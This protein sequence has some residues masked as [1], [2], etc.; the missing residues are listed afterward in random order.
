V[1]LCLFG[2]FSGLQGQTLSFADRYGT[3]YDYAELQFTEN[4]NPACDC[5]EFSDLSTGV[6]RLY[7]SEVTENTGTGFASVSQGAALRRSVCAAYAALN[8]LLQPAAPLCAAESPPRINVRV[9][10]LP[11]TQGEARSSA[12]YSLAQGY[13]GRLFGAPWWVFHTGSAPRG[14]A[15]DVFHAYLE[16]NTG[17]TLSAG[18]FPVESSSS[19]SQEALGGWLLHQALAG[20]GIASGFLN[21]QPLLH[22]HTS[23]PLFLELDPLLVSTEGTSPKPL[24]LPPLTED[25]DRQ[26]WTLND[27][28]A[29]PATENVSIRAENTTVPLLAAAVLSRAQMQQGQFPL[30]Q[31]EAGRMSLSPLAL[32]LLSKLG[33]ALQCGA[34]EATV[35]CGQTPL[36]AADDFINSD[37]FTGNRGDFTLRLPP[38]EEGTLVIDFQTLLANDRGVGGMQAIRHLSGA[39]KLEVDEA[40]GQL[41]YTTRQLG[42]SDFLYTP[43]FSNGEVGNSV[44]FLINT[45][46]NT[47]GGFVLECEPL[48]P[49]APNEQC[50][51]VDDCTDTNFQCEQLLCNP[52]FCGK[53][54]D[55]N[56]FPLDYC[57]PSNTLGGTISEPNADLI[58][59]RADVPNWIRV[60]ASPDYFRATTDDMRGGAA[61]FASNPVDS[62]D[63]PGYQN[64]NEESLMTYYDFSPDKCYFFSLIWG[65]ARP[66]HPETGQICNEAISSLAVELVEGD[67]IIPGGNT[68]EI[69]NATWDEGFLTNNSTA[70]TQGIIVHDNLPLPAGVAE[71]RVGTYFSPW[72]DLH[73]ALIV[74]SQNTAR[75]YFYVDDLELIEDNFTAG[76]DQTQDNC[77]E[78]VVL[79][80][81]FCMLRGVAVQYTWYEVGNPT[82]LVIYE[83]QDGAVTAVVTQAVF[84]NVFSTDTHQLSVY[85]TASTTY[86]LER[87]IVDHAGMPE[88]NFCKPLEDGTAECFNEDEVNVTVAIP[89]IDPNIVADSLSCGRY[90]FSV[91]HPEYLTSDLPPIVRTAKLNMLVKPKSVFSTN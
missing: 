45:V 63:I 64:G 26:R 46:L 34:V 2:C 36:V 42:R 29:T 10:S 67:S 53:I 43:I 84:P 69:N 58:Y 1:L 88:L 82:A 79:G 41:S 38:N 90:Q 78:P 21:A 31:T 23:R 80:A 65:P 51:I 7:F 12:Y 5:E 13:D 11:E 8:D 60:G 55:F 72:S 73:S 87:T 83:V 85:P 76:P 44:R 18:N 48:E 77:D 57:P 74:G 22:P 14:M 81:P 66:V 16:V 25:P 17:N 91:S 15:G 28:I 37:C 20:L 24:L 71:D 62:T 59:H 35:A 6:F 32:N 3:V 70:P 9:S 61:V 75:L 30:L 50:W 40:A 19:L 68:V 27:A 33:Y 39:G 56:F 89:P 54:A 86:R 49:C 47:S 52:Q 4:P